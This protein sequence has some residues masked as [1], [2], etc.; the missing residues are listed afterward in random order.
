VNPKNATRLKMA[1]GRREEEA[2]ER[3]GKPASGTV[4]GGVG[5]VDVHPG[6]TGAPTGQPD[7]TWTLFSSSVEGAWNLKRG[8]SGRETGGRDIGF[9]LCRRAEPH[10]RIA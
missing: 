4:V 7:G 1:G 2:A 8:A 10:E 6:K 3:L 5:A 9:I